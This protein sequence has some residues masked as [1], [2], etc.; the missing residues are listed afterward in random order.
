MTRGLLLTMLICAAGCTTSAWHTHVDSAVPDVWPLGSLSAA[1]WHT[2]ETNAEAS[3]FVVYRSEFVRHSP[4]LTAFGRSHVMEIAAR[5]PSV[6]FPV[7]VEPEPH[8]KAAQLD[9]ARRQ[10]VV[11]LLNELSVP[12][13]ASRTVVSPPYSNGQR[14]P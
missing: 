8:H 5:L 11:R 2:M 4:V 3:D 9:L 13:A 12:D 7:L 6:P 1:H 14:L 10:H